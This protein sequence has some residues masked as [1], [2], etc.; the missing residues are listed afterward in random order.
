VTL[1]LLLFAGPNGSGK[2]TI[3]TPQMLAYFAIPLERYI[4]ADDIARTLKET[5]PDLGQEA[6]EREAFRQARMLRQIYRD[7]GLSFAFETVFSHPSTLLDMQRCRATGFE[8][9]VVFVTTENPEI[10]VGRVAGRYQAGG[11]DVPVDR[12]RLRYQRTMA[13]LPRIVEEADHVSVYDNSNLPP[14][15]F[16]FRQGVMLPS[17]DAMPDF[18]MAALVEPLAHRREER[19][20]LADRFDE[21]AMPDEAIGVYSGE[22]LLIL[23][24]YFVQCDGSQIVRHDLLLLEKIE[25]RE[26]AVGKSVTITYSDGAG[27]VST[28]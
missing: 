27:R 21:L 26:I 13:L 28:A 5:H 8:V 9:F 1:R 17:R 2:S 20:I 4:N 24:H 22:V 10:N 16:P 23:D 7:E 25:A 14:R 15:V 6:R 3:T 19:K 11:H 12:I 18:L